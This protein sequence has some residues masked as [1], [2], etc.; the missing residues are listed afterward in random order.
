ML[1]LIKQSSL[2]FLSFNRVVE[3]FAKLL[4]SDVVD[5]KLEFRRHSKHRKKSTKSE[6]NSTFFETVKSIE[7]SFNF[8]KVFQKFFSSLVLILSKYTHGIVKKIRKNN[9][10]YRKKLEKVFCHLKQNRFIWKNLNQC[11]VVMTVLDLTL[12]FGGGAELLVG[13]IKSHQVIFP[14]SNNPT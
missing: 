10:F 1:N 5:D 2:L 7:V 3:V 12:E 13:K 14:F 9:N 4:K 8:K 11:F 6:S